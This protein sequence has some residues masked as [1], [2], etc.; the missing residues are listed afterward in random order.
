MLAGQ[1]MHVALPTASVSLFVSP[2]WMNQ[3]PLIQPALG[4]R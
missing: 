4:H 3:H 1:T 2:A